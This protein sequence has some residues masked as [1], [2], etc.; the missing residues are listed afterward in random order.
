MNKDNKRPSYQNVMYW[1]CWIILAG[2]VI[3]AITKIF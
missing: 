2:L 3:Y 1:L